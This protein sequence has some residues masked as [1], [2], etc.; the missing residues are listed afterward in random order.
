MLCYILV[1]SWNLL[2]EVHFYWR[3]HRTK[4]LSLVSYSRAHSFYCNRI[5]MFGG[6][7]ASIFM[8]VPCRLVRSSGIVLLSSLLSSLVAL[9]TGSV[10]GLRKLCRLLLVISW[11]AM[12]S[13]VHQKSSKR[14]SLLW[15][16]S[17]IVLQKL[18]WI[19]FTGEGDT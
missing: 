9:W 8:N 17:K 2:V 7:S 6:R 5:P 10:A 19:T 12:T 16:C 3:V 11:R 15:V 13:F 1:L 4:E 14:L 18:V